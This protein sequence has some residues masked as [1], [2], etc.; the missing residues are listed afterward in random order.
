MSESSFLEYLNQSQKWS[1]FESKIFQ[2]FLA[3]AANFKYGVDQ[4]NLQFCAFGPGAEV[5]VDIF[6]I[7][8]IPISNHQ[9]VDPCH[10]SPLSSSVCLFRDPNFILTPDWQIFASGENHFHTDS[11]ANQYQCQCKRHG[12]AILTG[13]ESRDIWF[14]FFQERSRRMIF[15]HFPTKI[16]LCVNINQQQINEQTREELE[17]ILKFGEKMYNQFSAYDFKTVLN[18]LSPSPYMFNDNIDLIFFIISLFS[19]AEQDSFICQKIISEEHLFSIYLKC[20]E[21]FN[22]LEMD[23]YYK[24]RLCLIRIAL[25]EE[26]I[27]E[28]CNDVLK[29]L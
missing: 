26:L 2:M 17:I 21:K 16:N 5:M 27:A 11:Q 18:Q 23:E 13:D 22:D 10:N 25:K 28:I 6:H 15:I 24:H 20:N 14:Q 9:E 8:N 29:F 4:W 7:L 19:S 12:I 1:P 3:R